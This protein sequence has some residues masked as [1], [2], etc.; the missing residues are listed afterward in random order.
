MDIEDYLELLAGFQLNEKMPKYE[1]YLETRDVKLITSL[2]KQVRGNTGLTDRQ[3]ELAKK[4]LLEYQDQFE[5]NDFFDLDKDLENLRI[6]LRNINRAKTV[7]IVLKDYFDLFSVRDKLM[8][9]VRFPYSNKMIKYI[10]F[11]KD[12]QERREYDSE[13]KTHFVEFT[14]KNVLKLVDKLKDAN[15]DIQEELIQ[16]YDQIKEFE[17]T[18]Q[19]YEPGIY[20]YKLK[21]VHTRCIDY[22]HNYF[23]EPCL[24][25][26]AIFYDRRNEFGLSYFDQDNLQ[27]SL[28]KYSEL[29]NKIIKSTYHHTFVD[30][31][32]FSLIDVCSALNELKRYPLLIVL[33]LGEEIENLT[34]L[35]QAFDQKIDTTDIAVM[36]RLENNTEKNIQFN[37][38]VK[39]FNFNNKLSDKTKVVI[40][41][42]EKITKPLLQLKWKPNTTLL[43]DSFRQKKQITTYSNESSLVIRYDNIKISMLRPNN[44]GIL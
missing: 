27:D 24:E 41:N 32:Q 31:N 3:H 2:A 25:N 36:Y 15:F 44:I 13:S 39:K 17:T 35:H 7:K 26:L 38:L 42:N 12:M 20:N 29:A 33:K 16:Y 11:I 18:P 19:N 30:N 34:N 4:K 23:G 1:F 22:M 21:N 8:I 10:N 37:E 6:E 43:C 5:K 14:E 9:A 40:I 28:L